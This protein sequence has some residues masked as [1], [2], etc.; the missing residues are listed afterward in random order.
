MLVF[1]ERYKQLKLKEPCKAFGA[2]ASGYYVIEH[3]RL[4]ATVYH[5]GLKP[6]EL[7]WF[8]EL[9]REATANCPHVVKSHG[10]IRK[11]PK[12]ESIGVLWDMANGK[13]LKEMI[14]RGKWAAVRLAKKLLVSLR[15]QRNHGIL[16]TDI[17]LENIIVDRWGVPKF[18][19]RL[20]YSTTDVV[21]WPDGRFEKREC[22]M[23]NPDFIAP[24][25]TV[26][27]VHTAKAL[28][29]S[30]YVLAHTVLKGG[31][32]PFD[33]LNSFGVKIGNAELE[34]KKLYGRFGTQIKNYVPADNGI[35][36]A[37]L[38]EEVQ[39]LFNQAFIRGRIT[40]DARPTLDELITA[41]GRWQMKRTAKIFAVGGVMMAPMI[42]AAGLWLGD[43]RPKIEPPLIPVNNVM[44]VPAVVPPVN[45][46]ERETQ[47]P[48]PEDNGRPP[49]WRGKK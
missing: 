9:L 12:G 16:P 46:V 44:T 18:I 7:D 10:V 20:A 42:F 17:H 27:G 33:T 41:L 1:N 38:S 4:F 24:E 11:V 22:Q 2:E 36:W 31:D 15:E 40:P 13:Y 37:K 45:E 6:A 19:D 43:G 28:D 26:T 29:H 34:S 30:A 5:P 47:Q 49:L 32:F 48:E 8:E 3:Q 35:K 14:P 39:W 25:V 21:E 23:V